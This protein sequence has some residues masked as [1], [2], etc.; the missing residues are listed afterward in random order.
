MEWHRRTSIIHMLSRWRLTLHSGGYKEDKAGAVYV[1][2]NWYPRPHC[3][4]LTPLLL[5]LSPASG[6]D[7][8]CALLEVPRGGL[9]YALF[10]PLR[11][12][13]R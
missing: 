6:V 7:S 11:N 8:R 13:Q 2:P 12:A 5:S 4:T 9:P 1:W 10:R 3:L